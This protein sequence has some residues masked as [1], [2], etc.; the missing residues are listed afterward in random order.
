LSENII[1]VKFSCKST[2]HLRASDEQDNQHMT[3]NL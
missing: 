1:F 3:T 2:P